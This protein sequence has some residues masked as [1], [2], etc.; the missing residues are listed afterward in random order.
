M[1]IRTKALI[2]L[3][4]LSFFAFTTS[5][6][7]KEIENEYALENLREA[8]APM[9]TS[10]F[11]AGNI[12]SGESLLEKGILLTYKNRYAENVFVSGDFSDWKSVKMKRGKYGVWYHF[13]NESISENSSRYKFNVDGIWSYDPLNMYREDDNAGS[14]VSLI[15]PYRQPENNMLTYRM[16]RPGFIEF[17]LYN[18]DAR[19]ISLV[20]D[21]NHWNPENDILQRNENGVWTLQ[22]RLSPGTYRYNYVIDGEWSIDLFNKYT[23]SNDIGEICSLINIKK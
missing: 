19:F 10:L 7:N 3:S 12:S 17:R 15:R 6:R 13:I 21:F 1:N 23:A 8:K 20:G 5:N 22:K 9:V 14:Y 2:L 18:P 16:L 11:R 4:T